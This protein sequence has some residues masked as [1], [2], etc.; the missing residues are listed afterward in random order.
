MTSNIH[1]PVGPKPGWE[2]ECSSDSSEDER[3]EPKSIA[4]SLILAY[5]LKQSREK[6][7]TGIFPRFS[8]KHR[9]GKST[10]IVPPPH[11]IKPHGRYDFTVGPHLFS[12]TAIY[13]VHY[14]PQNQASSSQNQTFSS[15]GVQN[16]QSS[17]SSSMPD[18]IVV[19]PELLQKVTEAAATNPILANLLHEA[20][21][22]RATV[23]MQQ[24][25]GLLIQSLGATN[26][27]AAS[28]SAASAPAPTQTSS[29]PQSSNVPS[30]PTKEFDVV[31]EFNERPSE[32]YIIPRG[33]VSCELIPSGY[34]TASG[35]DLVMNAV[36]PFPEAVSALEPASRPKY[37]ELVPFRWSGVSASVQDLVHRWS[38]GEEHKVQIAKLINEVLPQVPKRMFL[39]HR[40]PE[41]P[42]LEQLQA[43]ATSQYTT[44]PLKPN[45]ESRSR[46]RTTSTR[47]QVTEPQS[48]PIQQSELSQPAVPP[49][50]KRR[51]STIQQEK[52]G[53]GTSRVRI[54][55]HI[56]GQTDVPLMMGG[57][58]CRPCVE[59]GRA[60]ASIP[61]AT[62]VRASPI[63]TSNVNATPL[64]RRPSA[65]ALVTPSPLATNPPVTFTPIQTPETSGTSRG[66]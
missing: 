40:V 52:S 57:R 5:A 42:L 59:A 46:R 17:A 58:F 65:P 12:S 32:K 21:R 27:P 23:E 15:Q 2:L 6:W 31:I 25:L 7:L 53:T 20:H 41:G 47:K 28:T 33:R 48:S 16:S 4:D 63:S 18:G 24:R 26:P 56:C 66:T 61:P 39:Q 37:P 51:R 19:S 29:F 44:K 10:S 13:E 1:L 9:G 55:C 14:I 34:Y 50:P 60:D 30:S 64:A 54:A 35:W 49:P 36:L 62:P 38:G 3:P 45:T 22:G 11:T 43:A 8:V